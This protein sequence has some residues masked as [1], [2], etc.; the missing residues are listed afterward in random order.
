MNSEVPRNGR[1]WRPWEART[2]LVVGLLLLAALCWG[3]V[4]LAVD[5]WKYKKE[6]EA[7]AEPFS[8]IRVGMK[9]KEVISLVGEPTS[10]SVKD[11]IV[12][13]HG[14]P[15]EHRRRISNPNKAFYYAGPIDYLACIVFDAE[16]R[17]AYI[18]VGGT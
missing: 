10:I 4:G 5:I 3:L 2:A 14:K 13:H 8:K 18:N 12:Q 15:S 9:E 1:L 7:F 16:N 17:V 6:R 11:P